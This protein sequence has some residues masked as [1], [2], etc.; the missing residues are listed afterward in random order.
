M[1]AFAGAAPPHDTSGS[2]TATST[3]RLTFARASSGLIDPP[4]P[5]AIGARSPTA[6]AGIRVKMITGDH[7]ATARAIARQIGLR[8][9]TGH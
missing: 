4:R 8:I 9:L 6:T 7:A 2:T 3:A 5:E 1:L